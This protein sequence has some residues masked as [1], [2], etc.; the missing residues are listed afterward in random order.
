MSGQLF[1]VD[2]LPVLTFLLAVGILAVLVARRRPA[3]LV[4][5][6]FGI[7]LVL[8]FGRPSVAFLVDLL[9]LHDAL[10]LHRFVGSVDIAAIILMGIGG[11]VAVDADHAA[12]A[13]RSGWSLRPAPR[14]SC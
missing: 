11:A 14:C 7:W 12:P 4:L 9:P 8:Y 6:L 2:R 10:L 3:V 1:D 5:V 13:R